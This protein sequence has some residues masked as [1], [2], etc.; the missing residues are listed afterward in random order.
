[1]NYYQHPH[2]RE[3]IQKQEAKDSRSFEPSI[4]IRRL[5][6]EIGGAETESG[7]ADPRERIKKPLEGKPL[8]K[9]ARRRIV[10]GRARSILAR[11]IDLVSEEPADATEA[12]VAEVGAALEKVHLEANFLPAGFLRVGA[13]K[14][15]AVC[16]IP[17]RTS[18]G[19]FVG[20][21]FLVAPGIIMTNNHVLDSAETALNAV[22]EFDF[23]MDMAAR[24]VALRPDDLF[25]THEPLDFTLV[26]CEMSDI[27]DIEPIRLSRNPVAIMDGERVNI[28]QHPQGR[29]KEVVLHD[30]RVIELFED[31]V[32]YNA[33]TEGGSSGSPV[34]DND[35]NLIGLHHWGIKQDGGGAKNRAIRVP[36]I[37]AHI[38]S[39]FETESSAPTRLRAVLNEVR[40]T[41]PLLGFFDVSGPST[42]NA[43]EIEVPDWRGSKDFA[44]VGFWNIENFNRSVSSSRLGRVADVV[45]GLAMDTIGLEEVHE[46]SMN[47]LVSA[48][49]SQGL[50]MRFVLQNESGSQD[51]AVL[52]D[53]DTSTVTHRDDLLRKY[54]A[55]LTRRIPEGSVFP[56]KPLFADCTV[57]HRDTGESVSYMMIVLHLKA[58]VSHAPSRARRRAAAEALREI[59]DD[60]RAQSAALPIIIGGDYNELM[61]TDVLSSLTDSPDLFAMTLDDA[62]TNA[63]SYVGGRRSLIDHIVVS[64]DVRAGSINGDDAAIVRLDRSTN[65]FDDS[66]SDH[67]PIVMRLIFG[68]GDDSVAGHPG[69]SVPTGASKFRVAFFNADGQP[70]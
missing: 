53:A 14:A 16:R 20:S 45:A 35:W 67:V 51:L 48:L 57:R 24:R 17:F 23:E 56:R 13:Q 6:E 44:D 7:Q 50:E 2:V 39:R 64:S 8:S 36:A 25:Y 10:T 15:K 29:M 28:I 30:N 66:V 46:D 31:L 42:D 41:N 62:T 26:A 37:V 55:I 19:R 61:T 49:R 65:D 1:M 22:A 58:Y 59:I 21:G 60:L 12:L 68:N 5:S 38:R 54:D 47:R 70:V 43:L 3:Q 32:Y 69:L 4:D 34:F 18:Q 9:G 40:D 27:A 63:A 52:Y 11:K 33:D